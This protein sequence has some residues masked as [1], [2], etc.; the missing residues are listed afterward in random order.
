MIS[1]HKRLRWVTCK[2]PVI[3]NCYCSKLM[4]PS[5]FY[6]FSAIL[7]TLKH[8]PP[9]SSPLPHHKK[10]KKGKKKGERA[11]KEQ[12]VVLKDL[13]ERII[14]KAWEPRK[15]KD[16]RREKCSGCPKRDNLHSPQGREPSLCHRPAREFNR[17]AC[18]LITTWVPATEGEPGPPASSAEAWARLLCGFHQMAAGNKVC[19]QTAV[20]V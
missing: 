17:K 19:V 4:K 20:L 15:F 8:L 5:N 18:L 14:F 1:L 11:K 16:K 9:A 12:I 3:S 10:R 6:N 2:W 13:W 7:L